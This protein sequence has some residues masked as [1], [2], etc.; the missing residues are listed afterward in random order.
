LTAL[1]KRSTGAKHAIAIVEH[2]LHEELAFHHK[3]FAIM[4]R[5]LGRRG[6]WQRACQMLDVMRQRDLEPN[7]ILYNA[8]A[9]ACRRSQAWAVALALLDLMP[10]RS[11][12]VDVI[13][14][15]TIVAACTA[16]SK[17]EAGLQIF[18]ELTGRADASTK[19][20]DSEHVRV[21]QQSVSTGIAA[22]ARG[23]QWMLA[24]V[25]LSD[26]AP[27]VQPDLVSYNAVIDACGKGQ[28]WQR[29]LATFARLQ[30]AAL[31]P[32][33][34]AYN[35]TATA[36]EGGQRWDVALHLFHE[37]RPRSVPLDIVSY[38][39]AIHA[40]WRGGGTLWEVA[41]SLFAE[42]PA[43]SF[44]P[45]VATYGTLLAVHADARRWEG[46]LALLDEMRVRAGPA[47]GRSS[48][49]S[50][51][52][53][54][55]DAAYSTA[56]TAV[57]ASPDG[58][59]RALALYR[60]AE[61]AGALSPWLRS[62]NGVVDLHGHTVEV[63]LAA[64]HSVLADCAAQPQGRYCHDPARDLVLVTGRGLHS[65][66]AIPKL[67]PALA[68]FLGERFDPPLEFRCG[69]HRGGRYVVPAD[70]LQRWIQAGGGLT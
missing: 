26:F 62:E 10:H 46:A 68:S 32:D 24:L 34:V 27:E 3:H 29:G 8:A 16:A 48:A 11:A 15:S 37:M 22:C 44:S 33:A 9:D 21:D 54:V 23:A 6:L 50:A 69:T 41:V 57:S 13:T 61:A 56:I 31:K 49:A 52:L 2:L 38:N 25:F 67:I 65:D 1:S 30:A 42:L 4:I 59:A 51:S 35:T 18:A 66:G 12:I 53:A 45:T 55:D 63:A 28:Q 70:S 43:A 5:G 58:A 7:V 14:C 20:S 19:R 17:W 47:S 36:C 40:C 64:V 60:E 39:A